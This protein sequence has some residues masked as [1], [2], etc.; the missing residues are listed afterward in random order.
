MTGSAP[1]PDV[2]KGSFRTKNVLNDPF[3]TSG[4]ENVRS[5]RKW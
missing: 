1:F 3:M 5:R 2:M 4:V